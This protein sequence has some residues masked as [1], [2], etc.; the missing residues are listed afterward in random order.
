MSP[1]FQTK[2]QLAFFLLLTFDS[3]PPRKPVVI[4]LRSVC[5]RWQKN[6]LLLSVVFFFCFFHLYRTSLRLEL[7]WERDRQLPASGKI[8]PKSNCSPVLSDFFYY[9]FASSPKKK[10]PF[11][12]KRSRWS[13]FS[14]S[15]ARKEVT[16]VASFSFSF[17]NVTCRAGFEMKP[18]LGLY[19]EAVLIWT[20]KS[21]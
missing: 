6:F 14:F 10:W 15:R 8:W 18:Q 11:L 4:N 20:A 21:E 5:F 13:R 17:V 12:K 16:N 1:P 9:F 2:I 19:R 7:E 3:F